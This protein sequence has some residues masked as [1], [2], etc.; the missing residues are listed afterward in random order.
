MSPTRAPHST[1]AIGF[2]KSN[3]AQIGRDASTT[4]TIFLC[5]RGSSMQSGW[6]SS[7]SFRLAQGRW[8]KPA[9]IPTK[10]SR[11]ALPS[12]VVETSG[13]FLSAS[14]SAS[15]T[16]R[17]ERFRFE[18]VPV[19]DTV[20][21]T[22]VVQVA[23]TVVLVV[24]SALSA[25]SYPTLFLSLSSPIAQGG[26]PRSFVS[27]GSAVSHTRGWLFSDTFQLLSAVRTA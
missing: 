3:F 10:E 20:I 27:C 17:P 9:T 24:P 2:A 1:S 19:L 15:G 22:A 26:C 8:P 5:L 7:P 12:R 18:R 4:R 25:F 6:Y 11:R 21:G 16:G 13:S 14:E 23:V